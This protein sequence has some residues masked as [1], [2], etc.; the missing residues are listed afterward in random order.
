LL[1]HVVRRPRDE[2]PGA[3]ASLAERLDETL[4]VKRLGL[5]DR[6]ARQASTTNATEN[7]IGWMR[8]IWA[9]VKRW[10][11]GRM[12]LRWAIAVIA[13]AVSDF[14]RATG[15]REGMTRAPRYVEG[16]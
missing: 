14:R 3:A 15:A 9:R 6:P 16:R 2:H 7:V 5:P 1:V 13:D 11:N 12:T 8:Q 10:R 4:T